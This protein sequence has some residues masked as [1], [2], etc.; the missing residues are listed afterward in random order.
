LALVGFAG[1][2]QAQQFAEVTLDDCDASG[3]AGSSL[4]LSVE[5]EFS[6]SWIVT[7]TINT[8]NYFGV[9]P[10]LVQ[11]GFKAIDG[12][13]SGTVLS[14]PVGSETDWNPVSDDPIVN[15]SLCDFSIGVSSKVCIHGFVDITGG[16]DYTWI[17][18]IN[19]GALITDIS[20]WQLG[21]QY[22]D[23]HFLTIGTI[24]SAGGPTPTPT[25]IATPTATLTPTATP[26]ATPI[27][28]PTPTYV[29]NPN[30]LPLDFTLGTAESPPADFTLGWVF[31]L[32]ATV[33][34]DGLG[35][36]DEAA[37]GLNN[38][39]TAGL[40]TAGG[41]L[42][43][44][45]PVVTG[46]SV[47]STSPNGEWRFESISPIVLGPGNYVIGATYVTGDSDL[48]RHSTTESTSPEINFVEDRQ[49]PGGCSGL[50][51]PTQTI[52]FSA[53]FGP[54]LRLTAADL[55]D[56]MTHDTVGTGGGTVSTGTVAASSSNPVETEVTVP[57]GTAGGDVV[58]T[59]GPIIETPPV[60]FSFL[61]QQ[62]DITAPNGTVGNPLVL[63]FSAYAPGVDPNDVEIF[64]AGVLAG[65]CVAPGADPD[66][67]VESRTSQGADNV[68]IAVRT[69]TASPWNF[70]AV[71]EPGALWQLGSGIGLVALLARRR[72]A[73]ALTATHPEAP[74]MRAR[75]TGSFRRFARSSSASAARSSG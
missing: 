63:T 47:S 59:E 42:V 8:D 6:G 29:P 39:H 69:S 20:Q 43:A 46:T 53:F 37:S 22:A 55:S 23:G 41:T 54:N 3:C 74:G 11:I 13:T 57:A 30:P 71:P 50:T 68:V 33:R 31:T 26:T 70:G 25:P 58:I 10:G 34:A 4:Y 27:A 73:R 40:W 15:N 38:S 45:V 64:K 72:K 19:D 9:R 66:P 51:L 75:R 18:R 1:S 56:E 62:V 44:S 12:W 52:G 16:G 67:C 14:S 65:P 32:N 35:I 17:F 48:V 49:C 24:I 21:G 28:T 2:A 36:W 5:E 7:Y 60:G 61:G